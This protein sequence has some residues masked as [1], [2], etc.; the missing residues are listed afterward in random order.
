MR[1]ALC[2]GCITGH[3]PC[4]CRLRRSDVPAAFWYLRVVDPLH[5]TKADQ[6]SFPLQLCFSLSATTFLNW[7]FQVLRASSDKTGSR[8]T[9]ADPKTVIVPKTVINPETVINQKNVLNRKPVCGTKNRFRE[10]PEPRKAENS[11]C[12]TS[13]QPLEK[14]PRYFLVTLSLS[15]YHSMYSRMFSICKY[16]FTSVRQPGD[17]TPGS[18]PSMSSTN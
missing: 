8:K 15:R 9:P 13:I 11:F 5:L 7:S 3:H 12:K 10:Q 14:G 6:R 4:E 16:S 18:W 17:G 1:W 2:A